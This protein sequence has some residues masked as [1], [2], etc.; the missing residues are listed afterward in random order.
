MAQM[1]DDMETFYAVVF[2]IELG[3]NAWSNWFSAFWRNGWTY[4]DIFVV[5]VSLV[6]EFSKGS[7]DAGP[8]LRI[9]R[10]FRVL[11]YASGI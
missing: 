10:I 6:S 5:I 8:A 7:T 3:I 4:L 9:L 2:T 11:R 1:L